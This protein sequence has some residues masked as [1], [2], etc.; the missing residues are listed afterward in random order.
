MGLVRQGSSE[1]LDQITLELE[2]ARAQM[3]ELSK[4]IAFS[5]LILR[6]VEQGPAV[7]VP[8]S[9]DPF[10]WVDELGVEITEYR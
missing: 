2:L 5:T 10:G 9:N 6:F 4:S 3:R 7:S 1:A 8:S